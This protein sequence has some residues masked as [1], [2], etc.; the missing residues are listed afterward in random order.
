[1][2]RITKLKTL[3]TLTAL[4]LVLSQL[5][6]HHALAAASKPQV[7]KG[8]QAQISPQAEVLLVYEKALINEGIDA[9]SKYMTPERLA[10]MQ[11]MF[12]QFGPDSFKDFQAK[13]RAGAPQGEARRKQI[14][15]L[16]ID[17]DRAVLEARTG[18]N[19]LDEIRFRRTNEGWKV[20]KGR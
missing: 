20:D 8:A 1:M 9:A 5:V 7:R 16:S 15:T 4:T 12:K 14:E 2:P 10:D 11:E 17:D 6:G 3:A 19:M 13:M 18:P